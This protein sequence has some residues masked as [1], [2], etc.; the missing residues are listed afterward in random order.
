MYLKFLDLLL[1][2]STQGLLIFNFAE[3]LT[4]FKV[5]PER[6]EEDNMHN[7]N[8]YVHTHILGYC[9]C[10]DTQTLTVCLN[11]FPIPTNG[12]VIVYI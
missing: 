7:L 9:I 10:L 8:M 6:V 12:L 4:D 2:L 1:E 11:T 5:L 3:K